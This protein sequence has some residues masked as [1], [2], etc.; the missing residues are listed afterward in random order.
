M[1][2][3]NKAANSRQTP[4][5]PLTRPLKRVFETNN[6]GPVETSGKLEQKH[7]FTRDGVSITRSL[8]SA[9]LVHSCGNYE[10]ETILNSPKRRIEYYVQGTRD[11]GGVMYHCKETFLDGRKHECIKTYL[12]L[13]GILETEEMSGNNVDDMTTLRKSFRDKDG[14]QHVDIYLMQLKWS[15]RVLKQEK[16]GEVIEWN[17]RLIMDNERFELFNDKNESASQPNL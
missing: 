5:K 3:K 2:K 7:E 1:P 4:P 8:K 12:V 9:N 15:G 16:N 14:T 6:W 13:D 10:E 17:D 11:I